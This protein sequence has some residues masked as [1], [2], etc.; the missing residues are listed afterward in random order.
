MK[1]IK[2]LFCK[3]NYEQ[4]DDHA[5]QSCRKCNLVGDIYLF[6]CS[7]CGAEKWVSEDD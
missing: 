5:Y 1:F 3:H 6:R 4:T 7:D 2:R